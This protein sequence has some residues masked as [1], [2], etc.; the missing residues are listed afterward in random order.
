[1][2]TRFHRWAENGTFARMLQAAR[3]QADGAGNIAFGRP[4]TLLVTGGNI[5]DCTRFTTMTEA[6]RERS[7]P[8]RR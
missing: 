5:N 4:L 1:M 7:R 3:A 8:V 6:I 2:R